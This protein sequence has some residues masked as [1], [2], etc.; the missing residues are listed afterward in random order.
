MMVTPSTDP[1]QQQMM[2]MMQF[3]PI[4]FVFFSI[5]VPAGLVLYWVANNVFTMIQQWALERWGGLNNHP[6]VVVPA[7]IAE[8]TDHKGGV[9]PRSRQAAAALRGDS[10]APAAEPAAESVSR[11]LPQAAPGARKRRRRSR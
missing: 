4:M 1:N 7:N 5:S 9:V 2:K 10:P 8:S 6:P 3:M 11:A